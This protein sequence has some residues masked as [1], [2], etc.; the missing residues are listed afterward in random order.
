MADIRRICMG[1]LCAVVTD[2]THDSPKLQ[3]HGIPFIKG[4]HISGGFVDFSNCDYIT[5]EDHAEACRRVRPQHGDILF[6]NIGSVGDTALVRSDCE[7][8]I[9]NVA[10]LRA[11]PGKVDSQ[12]LYYLVL[13][14]E[15][16]ANVL[17]VRSGS[18]QPF[19]SLASLRSFEVSYQPDI[20]RQRRIAAILSAY[21]D[22]IE[23]NLRRIKILEEMARALYREWFVEFRFPGH[24]NV[25]HVESSFGSIPKGW[26]V[27]AVMNV[28]AR[29]PAGKVYREI[30]VVS[31]GLVPVVDQSSSEVLG[32][33][34]DRAGHSATPQ[35]PLAIFGDHTCKM[36]LLI[37]PF[38]VGPN[39]VVFG[40]K[41]NRPISYLFHVVRSLVK[42]QEYKRHWTS[43]V[44]KKIVLA[45]QATAN[46]FSASIQ[47]W[48]QLTETLRRENRLLRRTRDLLVPRLLSGQL[49]A[50]E[51]AVCVSFY[52]K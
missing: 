48:I 13:S 22:L 29:H 34:N 1:D 41:D 38:S 42:T 43:L 47:P 40:A 31:E 16:R 30:D 50:H 35:S 11:A 15:F 14:P 46:G 44:A 18:A 39:V 6:S 3:K 52:R 32:F 7:F 2:G 12:Y 33:H 27:T 37:E 5:P 21:D 17:N 10:L 25:P 26:T 9:K 28:L 8:S 45:D 24:M 36:Q 20:A 49:N 4:K 19:I 51:E 23:N